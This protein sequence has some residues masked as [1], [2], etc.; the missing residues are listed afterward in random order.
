M[1]LK[2]LALLFTVL[3]LLSGATHSD[4]LG[5]NC[6]G[7]GFCASGS[8]HALSE[9]NTQVQALNDGNIYPNG[10]HIACSGNICAFLQNVSGTKTAAQIKG[11]VHRLLDHGC[12][13]CGSVPTEP[14]NNVD[15]G[16]LTVNAVDAAWNYTLFPIRT[17]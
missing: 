14:G 15:F 7:S 9:I 2:A 11:Y 3:L 8:A 12:T 13:K 17:Y 10:Q 4:A 16:E 6:R 1:R 5:I